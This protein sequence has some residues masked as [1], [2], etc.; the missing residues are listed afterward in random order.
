MRAWDISECAAIGHT[1]K[2]ALRGALSASTIA[3]TAF[4]DGRAEA[5]F[6][7][8]V[9]NA[10][11]GTG[12]PWMLGTE[13]IYRHPREMIG[14]GPGW[15]RTMAAMAPR[16]SG[17]VAGANVGAIR[18]LRAWGFIVGDVPLVR[19]GVLFVP[20]EKEAADV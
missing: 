12:S 8:V 13:A 19:G 10:L 14:M 2:Q 1:P 20:F 17:Q 5:M 4:V 7:L 18:L 6:G 9:T 3:L 16:L 11:C 15:L